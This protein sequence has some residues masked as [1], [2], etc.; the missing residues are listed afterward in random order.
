LQPDI[1]L[2]LLFLY[3]Y[4]LAILSRAGKQTPILLGKQKLALFLP[5]FHLLP[6]GGRPLW[7]KS[8]PS[9]DF[10]GDA[11]DGVLEMTTLGQMLGEQKPVMSGD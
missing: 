8:K 2:L 11:L 3:L 10:G 4:S 9:R 1:Q 7:G 5:C 6:K